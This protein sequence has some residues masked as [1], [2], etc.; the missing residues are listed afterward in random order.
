ML[1]AAIWPARPP[2]MT[3]DEIQI[4]LETAVDVSEEAMRTAVQDPTAPAPALIA[5]AQ[6]MT[7]R[8]VG[9]HRRILPQAAADISIAT[10]SG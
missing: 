8:R 5:V 6:H 10:P 4:G 1:A 9:G 7:D 3:P 2:G